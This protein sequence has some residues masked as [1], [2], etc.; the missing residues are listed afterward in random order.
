M[1]CIEK[2]CRRS[3]TAQPRGD[4]ED[5][6]RGVYWVEKGPLAG[7]T[8]LTSGRN[9]LLEES[10]LS[11]KAGLVRVRDRY[12]ISTRYSSLPEL[13]PLTGRLFALGR[14]EGSKAGFETKFTYS[15]SNAV[16]CSQVT[17][18]KTGMKFQP[19]EFQKSRRLEN[20]QNVDFTRGDLS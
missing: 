10:S 15:Y 13:V 4:V 17:G 7:G 20:V 8:M 11:D 6:R 1:M 12:C 16:M 19:G 14:P 18:A 5:R 2:R 3:A 9:G